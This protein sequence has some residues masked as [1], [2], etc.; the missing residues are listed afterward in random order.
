[1]EFLVTLTCAV[2]MSCPL[3]SNHPIVTPFNATSA[4][5]CK[6]RVERMLPSKR[7][8]IPYQVQPKINGCIAISYSGKS[9]HNALILR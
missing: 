9:Y 5:D 7:C 6:A 1:M 4:H 2:A 3:P 8:G